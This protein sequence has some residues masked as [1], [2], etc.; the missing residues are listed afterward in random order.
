MSAR[1]RRRRKENNAQC[2]SAF[3]HVQSEFE[4]KTFVVCS[5]D[6]ILPI[7]THLKHSLTKI[8][9]YGNVHVLGI[10]VC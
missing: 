3:F 2:E 10:P 6:S 5:L 8:Q 7:I 4:I 1:E 9:P